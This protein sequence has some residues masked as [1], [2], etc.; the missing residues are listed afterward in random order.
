MGIW[1]LLTAMRVAFSSCTKDPATL[2]ASSGVL[3]FLKLP[4][5]RQILILATRLR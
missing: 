3:Y 5:T 1:S 2:E 4:I